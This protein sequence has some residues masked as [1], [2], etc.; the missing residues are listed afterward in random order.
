MMELRCSPGT[1]RG[2]L[3]HCR[4]PFRVWIEARE[5]LRQAQPERVSMQSRWA[6]RHRPTHSNRPFCAQPNCRRAVPWGGWLRSGVIPYN[7]G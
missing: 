2:R 4:R 1:V 6:G 3:H 5:G 7:I